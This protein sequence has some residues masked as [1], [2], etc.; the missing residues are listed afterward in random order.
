MGIVRADTQWQVTRKVRVALDPVLEQTTLIG[1]IFNDR[2]GDGYQDPAR[3]SSVVVRNRGGRSRFSGCVRACAARSWMVS[4][5][6]GYRLRR[7]H[8]KRRGPARRQ[9]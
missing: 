1:K 5:A 3:A 7:T 9:P 8:I 4:M 6:G 2:D